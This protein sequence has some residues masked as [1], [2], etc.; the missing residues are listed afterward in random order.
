MFLS[1]FFNFKAFMQIKDIFNT[2][3]IVD[4]YLAWKCFE[5]LFFH[6]LTNTLVQKVIKVCDG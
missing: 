3:Q 2:I 4:Y 6:H 1:F 5:L